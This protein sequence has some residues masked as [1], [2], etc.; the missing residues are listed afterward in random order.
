MYLL[1]QRSKQVKRAS[2]PQQS[3]LFCHKL[4]GWLGWNVASFLDANTA[5]YPSDSR[6]STCRL[7][8][9]HRQREI[10]LNRLWDY[11]KYRRLVPSRMTVTSRSRV[12]HKP[13]VSMQLRRF[14][15]IHLTYQ[16][17]NIAILTCRWSEEATS[18]LHLAIAV[19][20]PSWSFFKTSYPFHT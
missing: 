20:W 15:C 18:M 16:W 17:I 13:G 5:A 14:L 8:M 2:S 10:E 12:W 3:H 7:A 6:C 11:S 9:T 1:P 19:R 4:L